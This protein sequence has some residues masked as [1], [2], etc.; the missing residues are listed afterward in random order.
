MKTLLS[1]LLVATFLSTSLSGVALSQD[2]NAGKELAIIAY[3]SIDE[4]DRGY[5]DMAQFHIFG[6]NVFVSMDADDNESIDLE[7]FLF[8]DIGMKPI[9]E[10]RGASKELTTAM[11]VVHSFWDRNGDGKITHAEYR[12]SAINDFRRA[13][14]DDN[15]I[16]TQDEFLSGYIIMKAIRAAIAPSVK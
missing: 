8:W 1:S 5:I 10:E 7:E 3:K 2:M 12:S 16:L 6:E 14:I 13:D 15:A 4:K 11:R 9:A